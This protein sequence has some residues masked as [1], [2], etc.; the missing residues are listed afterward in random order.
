MHPTG[1]VR[2]PLPL[3]QEVFAPFAKHPRY[4]ELMENIT[5]VTEF[6]NRRVEEAVAVGGGAQLSVER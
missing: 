3:P 2:L 5:R 1:F 6:F 4:A